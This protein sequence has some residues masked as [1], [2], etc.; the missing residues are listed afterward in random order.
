MST[1]APLTAA[2]SARGF[3]VIELLVAMTIGLILTVIIAQLFVSTRQTYTA[4]EEQARMQES[5]RFA[6]EMLA[7]E[8]RQAGYKQAES[9]GSFTVAAPPLSVTNGSGTNESDE[10]TVRFFG[11]DGTVAGTSDGT[12]TDCRGTGATRNTVSADRFYIAANAAGQPALF[13]DSA[14]TQTELVT[15]VESLQVLL[16]EDIDGDKNAD[17]Y[18]RP[19]TAG[20]NMDNVVAVR[21]SLLMR[22]ASGGATEVDTKTYR[23][24]GTD[25]DAAAMG[26]A[27]AAFTP[28]TATPDRRIRRI[29][30]ATVTL[31]NRTN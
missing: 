14:G 15:D 3:S 4:Q 13:C 25:Y 30:Q 26:D 1:R 9:T 5:G 12:V 18:V 31:R 6:L 16:G 29:Y 21:V 23:H 22:T 20:M 11:S 8:L 24:F 28:P 19:G 17:R 2:A 10:F 27:G 7:R